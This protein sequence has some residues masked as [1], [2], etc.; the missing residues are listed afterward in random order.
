M[1]RKKAEPREDGQLVSFIQSD[2]R[3]YRAS[4]LRAQ[5]MPW[6]EIATQEGFTDEVEARVSVTAYIQRAAMAV[7]EAH[8][9]EALNLTMYRLEVLL[10][11]AWAHVEEGDLKA[12]DTAL[13]IIVQMAKLWGFEDRSERVTNNTVIVRPEDFAKTF[14]SHVEGR[15]S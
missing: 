4:L 2:D 13:R 1:P 15:A 9:V 10:Q 6:A 7:D 8:R 5:G 3:S 11:K 14:Q 12:I